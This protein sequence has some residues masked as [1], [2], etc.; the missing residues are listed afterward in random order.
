MIRKHLQSRLMI[1]GFFLAE[2]VFFSGANFLLMVVLTRYYSEF[3]VSAFGIGLSASLIMQSILHNCYMVHNAVLPPAIVRRRAAKVMGQHLLLWLSIAAAELLLVIFLIAGDYGDA[4]VELA[5][6]T[7]ATSLL[8][9]HLSFDRVMMIKHEKYASP[10]IAA[11]LYALLVTALF[12]MNLMEIRISFCIAMSL[13]IIFAAL[14]I[15]YTSLALPRPDFFW[16]FRL[17]KKNLRRNLLPAMNGTL[18]YTGYN[19]IPLFILGTLPSAMPAATFTAIRGLTQ[20][21]QLLIRSMDVIDK[22]FFQTKTIMNARDVRNKLL[23]QL[24]LYAFLAAALIIAA[25]FFGEALI[26]LAYGAK[27]ADAS[28]VL[29]GF[30][31]WAFL[32]VVSYP[33]ETVIVRKGRLNLY[34]NTRLIAGLVGIIAASFLATETYG[35]L[36]CIIA[37]IIG[38]VTAISLTLW[39]LRDVLLLDKEENR[40]NGVDPT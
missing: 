11:L 20:P 33:L 2:Q 1:K 36:G 30:S 14:K 15:L 8:Y 34:N 37:C 18:G 27:Y 22:N 40:P 9:G 17:A 3:Q 10:M 21:L 39:L 25:V 16:G 6:T 28:P 24:S 4:V 12:A 13:I 32:L 19:H 7:L 29:V 23:R 38:S 5:L 35:A 31:F 26:H